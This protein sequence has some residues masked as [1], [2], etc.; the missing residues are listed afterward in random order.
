M[1]MS[2]Y[3]KK[4]RQKIGQ[5]RVFM[6][7]VAAIIRNEEGQILFKDNGTIEGWSLPSGAIEPGEAPAQALIREV[8]EDTGLDVVPTQLTGVFGGEDFQ[9][10]DPNG[11]QVEYTLIVFECR[12]YSD[13]HFP[14]N[15]DLKSLKFISPDY[16]P[17]L[18][19]PYPSFI[20]DPP[21]EPT[22]THFQWHPGWIR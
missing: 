7:S 16:T 20:F 18:S 12:V 17:A 1:H 6:P 2:S 21:S 3:Y 5:E 4:L 15:P 11:D 19:L 9:Y 22:N 13:E 8:R 10:E 14:T